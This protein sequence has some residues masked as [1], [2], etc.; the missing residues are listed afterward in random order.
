MII[1]SKVPRNYA[2]LPLLKYLSKRFTYNDE[3]RW[4]EHIEQQRILHNNLP[5]IAYNKVKT[6]DIVSFY[7]D[8]VSEPDADLN[9]RIFYE[10][11]YILGIDK[12][13]NLLVHRNGRSFRNNLIFQLRFMHQPNIYR[14]ATVVHRLDRETSGVLI[15]AKSE[16]VKYAMQHA[17]KSGKMYKQYICI[18]YNTPQNQCFMVK[19]PIGRSPTS[20]ISYKQAIR[21]LSCKE[22][23]TKFTVLSK[24]ANKNFSLIKAEP[25]TGRTH[26]LRVHLASI[27]C[28]IAGD[29]LYSLPEEDYI[30]WRE[31]PKEYKL[32]LINR[33]ALHCRVMSFPHPYTG[34]T[35]SL[36]APVHSDIM[37]LIKELGLYRDN[38]PELSRDPNPILSAAAE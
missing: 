32:P 6:D 30:E 14:D 10:D 19:A 16:K 23:S 38:L 36:Q 22:A 17:W 25:T 20:L 18:A 12:P 34:E 21:G 1:S 24:S 28:P 37:E 33:Q 26:Q 3:E 9:Y 4:K 8:D 29:K 27:G 31:H 35:V 5:S 2:N 15:I 11:D 13:G 7:I